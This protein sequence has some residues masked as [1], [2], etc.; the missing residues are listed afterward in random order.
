[1]F[2]ATIARHGRWAAWL[3][4]AIYLGCI[5]AFIADLTSSNTL[6]FG[7]FYAPLVA[8]AVFHRDKRA[9]WVLTALACAMNIIGAFFPT[10]DRDVPELV[11]N[12]VLSTAALLATAAFTWHARMIQEQIARQTARAEAAERIK[13]QVLTNLSQEIRGPLHSMI[14][15]LELVAADSR[16]EQKAA[17]G[18]VRGAGRRLAVTIDNLVDLTQLEGRPM[19]AEPVDLG[20]L[21]R[22]TAEAKRSDAVARQIILSINIVSD[23]GTMVHANQW[24]A[25]RILEN[26]IDD[27][28]TYTAPGG[29]ID[30]STEI[31]GHEC[32]AVISATGN[33]PPGAFLPAG[34]V[35]SALLTP[36]EMGLALS[37]RLA[38]AMNAHLV[39]SNRPGE[40]TIVRL[41][42]P[43]LARPETEAA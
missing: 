8:T 20:M 7:V 42:L 37:H 15:V 35:T 31:G 43:I 6:A 39:F 1:M 18:M 12:R 4:P 40:G 29:R 17:L 38:R 14:G 27:A 19:P 25:R 13:T 32:C 28:I 21:L 11:G 16:S 10:L 22:Q 23:G 24:A 36:S 33:W 2:K 41:R 30:V 26:K 34:D 5:I 3:V 9:V